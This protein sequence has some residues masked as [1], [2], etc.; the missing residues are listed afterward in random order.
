MNCLWIP[1]ALICFHHLVYSFVEFP[2]HQVYRLPA[3]QSLQFNMKPDA[4][5]E[6]VLYTN[7]I[8]RAVW[9][10]HEVLGLDMP[11]GKSELMTLFRIDEHQVLLIF[12]PKKTSQPDRLVPSHG[13]IGQGHLALRIKEEDYQS[14]LDRLGEHG[15]DIEQEHVWDRSYHA[16]SIYIRD[17]SENSI[18]LITADIWK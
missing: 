13:A 15:I 7:D 1:F 5:L 12:D 2:S 18:E 3:A 10:Y 16:Q 9:F 6:T 8:D 4:I 11:A 14:W 17:P